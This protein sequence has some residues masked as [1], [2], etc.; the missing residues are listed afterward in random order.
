MSDVPARRPGARL[1]V[2]ETPSAEPP[3]SWGQAQLAPP[4]P[5]RHGPLA[6][7]TVAP[8]GAEM[9]RCTSQPGAQ[10][11]SSTDTR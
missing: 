7:T 10:A 1:T 8:A 9:S 5:V 6:E 2:T 11:V 3:A 4:G